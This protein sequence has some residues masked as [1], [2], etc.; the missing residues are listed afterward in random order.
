MLA[1]HFYSCF[2]KAGLTALQQNLA[3]ATH[4]KRQWRGQLCCCLQPDKIFWW[5]EILNGR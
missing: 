5:F 1:G 3:L 4:Q 2:K